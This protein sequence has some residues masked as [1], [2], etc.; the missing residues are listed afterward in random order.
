MIS[1]GDILSSKSSTKCMKIKSEEFYTADIDTERLIN[2]KVAGLLHSFHIIKKHM[3]IN[4]IF[5]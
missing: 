5:H 3:Q 4:T 2:I 1:K